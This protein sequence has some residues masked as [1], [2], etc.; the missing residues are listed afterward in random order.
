MEVIPFID[1]MVEAY[2]KAH[3]V[4]SRAGATTLFEL[5]AVGRAAV[6]IP[7]PYAVGDHQKKNAQVLARKKAAIVID[8]REFNREN[9]IKVITKF[10]FNRKL[11]IKMAKNMKGSLK[12][13][14]HRKVKEILGVLKC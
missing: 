4:I 2:K 1:N 14:D 10:Y 9:F 8:N 11:L 5:S 6:L 7:Y 3:L 13:L 12:S